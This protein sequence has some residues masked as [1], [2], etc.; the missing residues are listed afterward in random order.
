MK[1]NKNGKGKK[2]GLKIFGPSSPDPN[3]NHTLKVK[4]R[5]LFKMSHN[6]K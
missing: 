6:A 5:K 4:L 3:P 2:K 1:F